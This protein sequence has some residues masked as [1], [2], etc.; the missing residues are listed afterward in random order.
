MIVGPH[1]PECGVVPPFRNAFFFGD[2]VSEKLF[3]VTG[4]IGSPASEIET[5]ATGLRSVDLRPGPGGTLAYVDIAD[6][7]VG[8]IAHA[9]GNKTPIASVEATPAYGDL[10]LRVKLSAVAEDPDGDELSYRWRL[11]DGKRA[12]GPTVRHTYRKRGAYVVRLVVRDQHGART[13]AAD[14]VFAGNTPPRARIVSPADGYRYVAGR[15]IRLRAAG[16]DREDGRL[17]GRAFHWRV[18]LH[19]GDHD[20][21]VGDGDRS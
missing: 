20:H 11:G 2:Y 1:F 18:I 19:H 12:S 5:I 15:P 6:G 4:G 3:R 14:T 8:A 10:P 16:R 21:Y 13:L 9:P 7:V 17:P